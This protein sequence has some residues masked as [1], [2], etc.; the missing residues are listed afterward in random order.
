MYIY[1]QLRRADAALHI[2]RKKLLSVFLEIWGYAY[3]ESGSLPLDYTTD[4]AI[5]LLYTWIR[6]PVTGAYHGDAK[7]H[8]ATKIG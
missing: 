3:P 5:L 7:Q 2:K 4:A 8:R 1:P 6:R